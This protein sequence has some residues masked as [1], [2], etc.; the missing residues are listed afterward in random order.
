[1]TILVDTNV[2]SELVKPVPD[3]R[4]VAWLFAN[5]R[6]T[7]LS[8]LVVAE[9]DFGIRTTPGPA[10]RKLLSAWLERLVETHKGRIVDFNLPAA[11]KWAGFQSAVLIADI[12]AGTR[13]IDTLLAAQALALDV[14]L[15]TRNAVHFE[16]T[17]VRVINPWEP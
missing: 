10:K 13:T 4:V 1:L 5:R 14:A 8:S 3:D 6:E 11:R 9:I 15:V 7:L 17:D 12:R 2:F 16:D